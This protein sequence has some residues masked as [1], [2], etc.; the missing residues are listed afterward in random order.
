MP[1]PPKKRLTLSSP[2]SPAAA[3]PAKKTSPK[4]IQEKAPTWMIEHSEGE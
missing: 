4:T 3:D 2:S 1:M